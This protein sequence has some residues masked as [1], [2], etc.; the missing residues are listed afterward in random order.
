MSAPNREEGRNDVA[1]KISRLAHW[2]LNDGGFTKRQAA[3]ELAHIARTLSPG[4]ASVALGDAGCLD[5]DDTQRLRHIAENP[6][7]FRFL[8]DMLGEVYVNNATGERR[9][10]LKKP[11][12]DALDAIRSLI[13]DDIDDKAHGRNAFAE[14]AA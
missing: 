10:G 6:E 4:I 1:F 2:L 9:A 12:A 11:E 14:G 13:D 7:S 5:P 8:Y 3:L